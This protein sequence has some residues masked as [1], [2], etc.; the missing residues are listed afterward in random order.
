MISA[1][2]RFLLAVGMA[3]ALA[4]AAMAQAKVKV[5]THEYPGSIVHLNNWVMVAKGFCDK[6][7]LICEPVPLPSGPLAQSAAAAGSVDLIVSSADVMMQ[8][9]A[10]G[11]DLMILGTQLTNNVYGMAVRTDLLQT[12][13]KFPDNLKAL[14][15]KTIGVSARGS[16]TEMY[17][18]ALLS[19]AGIA[20]DQVSFVAVGVPAT[21]YAAIAAK[22]VD[23]ALTWDPVPAICS[24]TKVC[25]MAVDMR[26]G[27]GP[28]A[29]L[30]MNGGFVVWQA[31]REYVEKNSAT[32]DAFLRALAEA[33]AWLKDPK[34]FPEAL[35]IVKKNI[36]L[37]DLPERE[38]VFEA[39]TREG[40]SQYGS[41]FDRK[42]IKGFNDFLI[43]NKL[44]GK[45]LDPERI[46]Y[47]NA[48]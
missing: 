48:P 26:K 6:H 8:A 33:T 30:A 35:E 27:E 44:I 22:Q 10:N 39:I 1:L 25:Q 23:A 16:A 9:V 36:K 32:I 17:A 12:G 42:A 19:E 7:G 46:V 37:G 3:A 21:A 28:P 45:P 5:R 47:K 18:K 41:T 15:G 31:R 14:K 13:A 29:M 24:A 34:N 40:I 4:P 11:N 2:V 38:K 20:A 43:A